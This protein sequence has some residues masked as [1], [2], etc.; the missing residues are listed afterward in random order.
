MKP[1]LHV[2]F[3]GF[4][5]SLLFFPVLALAQAGAQP[6]LG[7]PSVLVNDALAAGFSHQWPIMAASLLGLVAYAMRAY[8]S[9]LHFFHTKIGAGVLVVGGAVIGA[10]I[11]VLA[12]GKVIWQQL[13]Q[14][15]L[16]AAFSALAGLLKPTGKPSSDNPLLASVVTTPP[17]GAK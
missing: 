14:C 5:L 12:T 4:F 17:G 7:D 10:L 13:V 15:G 9:E 6:V 1:T 16:V 11:P 8:S 3:A 2:F